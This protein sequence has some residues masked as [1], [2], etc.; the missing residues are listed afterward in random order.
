MG[1]WKNKVGKFG[2]VCRKNSLKIP[3]VFFEANNIRTKDFLKKNNCTPIFFFFEG[4]FGS[5]FE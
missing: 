5:E 4:L 1:G 2:E 3:A